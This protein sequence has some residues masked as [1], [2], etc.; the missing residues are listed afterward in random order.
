MGFHSDSH[1]YDDIFDTIQ[2]IDKYYCILNSQDQ[3][4]FYV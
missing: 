4:N 3:K 2:V 1:I